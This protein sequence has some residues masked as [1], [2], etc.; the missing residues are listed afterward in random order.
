M[1]IITSHTNADF[2]ALASMVAAKK[3]YP[4][5]KLVFPG[6]Q[7]KS[8]RDF[9][10]ESA[11]YTMEV[12]RLKNVDVNSIT[13]LIIVDNR[14]PARLGKLS[15]A[16]KR[17]G[18]PVHI[19]DHHPATAGDIKGELEVVEE[20]GATTTLM[21]ELLRQKGVPVTPLEATVFALGIYEE[22]GSLTFISTTKRDAE[23]AAWLISQGAQLNIVSDFISRE[24]TPEQVS[25][26]NGL[27][28]GAT[29]FDINGV[30]VVIT[31]M[32]TT[33]FI[34]DLANLAH[35]MRDMESL[36]VLFLVVQ[37]GEKTHIIARCRVPQVNAGKVLE[38]LGEGG[39]PRRHRQRSGT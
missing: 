9:F 34:P 10:L 24:L 35:K 18:L 32:A 8:M 37:M 7:E 28:E 11:F 31:A 4:G 33:H 13:R 15:E 5:A 29:S 12:E 21:V 36:N 27:V 38:E 2:D 22:T 20:I 1:D 25:V 26:L 17:P 23:A 39:T 30:R 3:L 19:Y 6:S 16:L 14:N